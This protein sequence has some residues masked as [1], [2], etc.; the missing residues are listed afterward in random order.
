MIYNFSFEYSVISGFVVSLSQNQLL[1]NN[2]G[3]AQADYT[4]IAMGM[5]AIMNVCMLIELYLE[6]M[7][8][9]KGSY[10]YLE[11]QRIGVMIGCNV[12]IITFS[13]MYMILGTQKVEKSDYVNIKIAD[14]QRQYDSIKILNSLFPILVVISAI[15]VWIFVYDMFFYKI[16]IL[17]WSFSK[18]S[19]RHLIYVCMILFNIILWLY[20]KSALIG[21]SDTT[22]QNFGTSFMFTHHSLVFGTSSYYDKLDSHRLGDFL[23]FVCN[24]Y[25]Q[26]LCHLSLMFFIAEYSETVHEIISKWEFELDTY[27]EYIAQKNREHSYLYVNLF[28]CKSLLDKSSRK[29]EK[30]YMNINDNREVLNYKSNADN[31]TKDLL[32]TKLEENR[33]RYIVQSQKRDAY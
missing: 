22:Y 9:Y 5:C 10:T 3:S 26:L 28:T 12:F 8:F 4:Q 32:Y 7:S 21:S 31:D 15:K 19:H 11:A 2:F 16:A 1:S 24:V 33:F 25:E 30:I 18:R 20:L 23:I 17:V 6:I 29:N 27:N 14:I 13:L